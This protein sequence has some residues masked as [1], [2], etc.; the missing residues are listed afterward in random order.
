MAREDDRDGRRDRRDLDGQVP[1][2]RGPHRGRDP[3][4]HPPGLPGP[5]VHP[6]VLRLRLQEQGRPAP[7]GRGG[8]LHAQPPGRARHQGPRHG[9]Q[10]GGA[11]GQGQRAIQRADLQDHGRPLRGI[12]GLHPG[13]LRGAGRRQRGLQ[14]QQAAARPHRPAAAD[15]RQQARGH[16]GSPHRRHRRGGGLQGRPHRPDHLRRGPP[17]DPGVHG[18]PRSGHP[19]VHR[20]QDQGGPGEDGHR[21]QPP[22]PG[23]PHLQGEDRPRDRPDHHRRHGRAAPGDHRRPHDARVQG[24]SQRRQAHGGLPRDHPQEG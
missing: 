9:R 18:L 21:P 20:A 7:A 24:G 13:L 12:P 4:G 10:R 3:G 15:A 8:Q 22:G 17:G 19:G 2:R 16:R 1:H 11:P 5:Q 6:H 23:G 14:L